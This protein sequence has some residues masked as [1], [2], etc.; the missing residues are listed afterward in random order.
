MS[1]AAER[2][3]L[4]ATVA[5][6]CLI[7]F[8][9]AAASLAGGAAWLQ[10]G[11]VATDLDSHFRYL[12][13]IFLGLAIGFATCVPAIERKGARLRLLGMMVVLGGCARAGSLLLIGA[14]SVGHLAGLCVE[15]GAVPLVVLWQRSLA[16]R[17]ERQSQAAGS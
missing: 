6:L 7:P 13:G 16:A 14:P 8:A 12:S 10:R 15:L 2:R 11:P 4:Q 5:L 17:W 1:L 9:T 3:A